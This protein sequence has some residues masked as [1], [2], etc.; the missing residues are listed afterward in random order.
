MM[1]VIMV[2]KYISERRKPVQS[3]YIQPCSF[4]W[5]VWIWRVNSITTTDVTG[6]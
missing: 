3:W 2:G 5:K 4:W 1:T 6:W